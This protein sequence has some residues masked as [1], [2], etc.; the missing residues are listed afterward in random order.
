MRERK[1]TEFELDVGAQAAVESRLKAL[2]EICQIYH[3]PMY[4]TVA[5]KNS[6]KDTIYNNIVYSAT[7]HQI[8]LKNDRIRKH[9][10]I[11][12]GFPVGEVNN[13]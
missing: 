11:A 2:L 13:K 12:A 3:A 7:A 8:V 6:E 9:M 10:L 5:I 1:N 4:A